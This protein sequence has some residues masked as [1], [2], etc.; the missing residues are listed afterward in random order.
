MSGWP[1]AF[2]R[3]CSDAT[4]PESFPIP[5][6]GELGLPAH[7]VAGFFGRVIGLHHDFFRF[8][9]NTCR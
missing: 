9:R 3:V 2:F 8:C 6:L 5:V 4:R 7:D 1:E